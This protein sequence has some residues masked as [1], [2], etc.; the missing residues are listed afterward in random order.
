[1][2]TLIIILLLL[3]MGIL[4]PV[5]ATTIILTSDKQLNDLLDPD[6]KVDL[7]TGRDKRFA[8]LREICESAQKRGDKILT[9]AFDEF[10]RQYREQAGTERRLTPDMD[11]YIDKIKI[12][13]DF[14]AKYQMGIG[15]SLLSPLELG[16]AYKKYTG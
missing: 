16:S 2:K 4:S 6:K 7:S 10:F 13:A 15:L 14:A 5:G 12:I 8:S 9:I 11:E 1:M 3:F